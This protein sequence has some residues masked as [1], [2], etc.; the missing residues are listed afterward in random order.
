[1]SPP[2]AETWKTEPLRL[3]APACPTAP[4]SRDCQAAEGAAPAAPPAFE[5]PPP[6]PPTP[7]QPTVRR[8]GMD[9][10]R[11]S[12]MVPPPM[13]RPAFHCPRGEGRRGNREF[14]GEDLLDDAE[15]LPVGAEDLE[16]VV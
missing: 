11:V 10:A 6:P 12:R 8:T 9:R 16:A 5:A 15:E 13:T 2:E 4:T 3:V 1:M 14:R 7:P